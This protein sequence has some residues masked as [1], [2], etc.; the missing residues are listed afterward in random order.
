V[1]E[2]YNRYNRRITLSDTE[3]A[4]GYGVHWLLK[5]SADGV[6][7][8]LKLSVDGVHWLLKL[9]ADGINWLLKLSAVNYVSN[10]LTSDMR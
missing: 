8:L 1:P 4:M 5:L 2:A 9:I 6:H 7:W 3:R 10:N